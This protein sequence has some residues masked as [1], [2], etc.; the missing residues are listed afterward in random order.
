[1]THPWDIVFLAVCAFWCAFF[2]AKVLGY[3]NPSKARHGG[4]LLLLAAFATLWGGTKPPAPPSMSISSDRP[5]ITLGFCVASGN[6]VEL[7]WVYQAAVLNDRLYIEV[8]PKGGTD[9][10][11]EIIYEGNVWGQLA[12]ANDFRQGHW[13]GV[14]ED[15]VDKECYIWVEYVPPPIVHT[16][17]V[18]HLDGVMPALD[19]PEHTKYVTPGITITVDGEIATPKKED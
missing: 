4:F 14:I 18:F 12:G 9:N 8:R 19:A 1:M 10:D 6:A 16:N 13:S 2:L 5:Y 7:N 17:G 15:A 3:I 11:W